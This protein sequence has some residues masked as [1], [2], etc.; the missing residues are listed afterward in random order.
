MAV[1]LVKKSTS[2]SQEEE[3][4]VP[5]YQGGSDTVIPSF[6]PIESLRFQHLSDNVKSFSYISDLFFVLN[7]ERI[8]AILGEDS[9]RQLFLSMQQ[10]S[11]SKRVDT[12]DSLTDDEKLSVLKSRFLQT[13]GEISS[14]YSSLISRFSALKKDLEEQSSSLNSTEQEVVNNVSSETKTE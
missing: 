12:L 5:S 1:S 3:F 6:Q 10:S 11:S 13:K 9:L 8:S 2:K 14:W 7:S 4:T